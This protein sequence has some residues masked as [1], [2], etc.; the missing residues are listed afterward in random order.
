M[1]SAKIEIEKGR[2]VSPVEPYEVSGTA[3]FG[4]ALDLRLTRGVD[5]KPVGAGSLV[6]SITGTVAEPRVALTPAPETQARLKP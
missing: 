2:L 1:R 4:R 6:Y 3:T 5:V